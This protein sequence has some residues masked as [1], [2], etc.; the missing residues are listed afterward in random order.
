MERIYLVSYCG[1]GWDDYYTKAL[2][3]THDLEKAQKYT[4]K[5]NGI[6]KK[7]KGWYRQYEDADGWLLEKFEK[8]YSNRW[9]QLHGTTK[10][11]YEEIS[12]R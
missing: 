2:F 1:G 7:W 11:Y 4:E 10:C 12:I 8:A 9:N 5:F 6:L 3:V